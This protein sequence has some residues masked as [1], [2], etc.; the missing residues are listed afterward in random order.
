MQ[1]IAHGTVL[2]AVALNHVQ[3]RSALA[4]RLIAERH[5]L[6]I[7][8]DVLIDLLKH[9]Y[10]FLHESLPL[11]VDHLTMKRHLLLPDLQEFQVGLLLH[12]QQR[13]ALKQGLVVAV[14]RLDISVVVLRDYHIHQPPALLAATFDE[15]GVA[16]RNEDKGYQPDVLRQSLIL[17]LI[18]LE[19]LLRAP[20]HSAIDRGRICRVIIVEPLQHEEVLIMADHLRVDARIGTMAE[21]QVIDRIQQIGLAHAVVA[22]ETIDLRRQLQRCL[23]DVLIVEDG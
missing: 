21:R 9:R 11:P 6:A 15:Q 23:P 10:Q 8:R 13:V 1:R 2:Q 5:L 22:Y 16:R 4:M 7:L 17:L 18:A 19:V 12:L 3:E 20:F 14:E